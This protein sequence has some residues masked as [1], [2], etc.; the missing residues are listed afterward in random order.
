MSN[1]ATYEIN[2]FNKNK[3]KILCLFNTENLK[4]LV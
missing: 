3:N 1:K 4:S 2:L